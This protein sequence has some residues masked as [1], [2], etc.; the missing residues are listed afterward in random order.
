LNATSYIRVPLLEKTIVLPGVKG[1]AGII[2]N[3]IVPGT[4][5]PGVFGPMILA[6]LSLAYSMTFIES[7]MGTCSGIATISFIPFSKDS[8]A[9][10]KK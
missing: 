8:I 2:P 3:L 4:I 1:T 6:P 5:I 7:L 10:F 9:A